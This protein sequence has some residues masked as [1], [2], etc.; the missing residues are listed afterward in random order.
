MYQTFLR[1]FVKFPRE[2]KQI[3]AISLAQNVR[4][5]NHFLASDHTN[6]TQLGRFSNSGYI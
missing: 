1:L 5:T 4:L 2:Y 6:A 3:N